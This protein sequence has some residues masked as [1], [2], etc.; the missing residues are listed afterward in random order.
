MPTTA[1]MAGRARRRVVPVLAA[2]MGALLVGGC[3]VDV[4]DPAAPQPVASTPAALATPTITPGHDAAAVAAQDLPFAAGG[5]LAP[6][7]P[8][9]IGDGLKDAPGWKPAGSVAAEARYAKENGCL[10]AARVSTNQAA[11][12]RGDDRESTV[13]LFEYLDPSILP[14]YLKTETLQWGAGPE[15]PARTVEVLALEQAA[16]PAGRATAVLARLFGTAGSSVYISLSCPDAAALAGARADVARFL[17]VVP[18]S[19]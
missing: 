5:S 7:M 14:G 12:V 13:A 15:G 17:P 16:Q 6:G 4:R 11:L 2:A 9:G 18:P 19:A 1:G 10:V 8:V 3:S